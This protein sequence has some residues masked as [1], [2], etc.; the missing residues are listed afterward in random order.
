[1]KDEMQLKFIHI[2][3]CAGTSIENIGKQ[4]NI[5]WGR[6][7]KE[8]GSWHEF[9]P[10]K[11]KQLKL[12]YDW[13]TVV[14]NPYERLISEFYCKWWGINRHGKKDPNHVN[15]EEFNSHTK[16]QIL[17]RS[18][19]GDHYSEQYRYIDENA[20]IHIL[21]FENIELEFNELMKKYKL[22]IKLNRKDNQATSVK[23]FTI[24]SFTPE[25]IKLINEVYHKDFITFD[26]KK[27]DK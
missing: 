3:K 25:L 4:N 17:S 16:S 5:L 7:H 12:E 14:R 20:V 23:K 27:I 15:E 10:N 22:D 13:F 11:T 21:H 1:M 19:V 8:Y 24:E 6:F 18:Q 26:Y 9:F 2:T